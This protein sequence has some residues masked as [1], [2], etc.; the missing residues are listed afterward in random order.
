MYKSKA[1]VT[2]CDRVSGWGLFTIV[3]DERMFM[4]AAMTHSWLQVGMVIDFDLFVNYCCELPFFCFADKPAGMD[5]C[6]QKS[7]S[8]PLEYQLESLRWRPQYWMSTI[9]LNYLDYRKW[10]MSDNYQMFVESKN[11]KKHDNNQD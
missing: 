11:L 4:W 1:R 8:Y 3:I 10:L 6:K 7:P 9:L 2:K 5:F